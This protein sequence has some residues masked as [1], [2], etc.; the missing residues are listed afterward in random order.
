MI[1]ISKNPIATQQADRFVEVTKLEIQ[2]I[3]KEIR[4]DCV[5]YTQLEGNEI[6]KLREYRTLIADNTIRVNAQGEYLPFEESKTEYTPEQISQSIGEYDFW[7]S[8]LENTT[9]SKDEVLEM[10]VL[11]AD[12]YGGKFN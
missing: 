8:F 4:F 2:F 10:V 3:T 7:I 1:Q 12:Q 11:R 6:V 5:V 9:F